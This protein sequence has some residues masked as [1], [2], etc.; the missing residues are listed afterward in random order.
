MQTVT[1]FV[2]PYNGY[3]AKVVYKGEVTPYK[4]QPYIPYKQ[5]PY[6]RVPSSPITAPSE[7]TEYRYNKPYVKALVRTT[8]SPTTY[9]QDAYPSPTTSISL[10]KPAPSNYAPTVSLP[11]YRYFGIRF[12]FEINFK[13]T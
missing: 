4:Y 11:R 13:Y 10:V 9:F 3:Q 5:P 8:P 6:N 1:Y 2:D 12:I 7:K